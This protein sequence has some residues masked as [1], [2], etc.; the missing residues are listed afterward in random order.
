MREEV[1][2][3]SA[4]ERDRAS[5]V[6]RHVEEGLGQREA[7]EWL[8]I[9]VRQ[10]KRLVRDWRREGDAGL[11]S[12]QRGRPSNNRLASD[13]RAEITGL[14]QGKYEG[15]GPTLAAE[16]LAA[17]ENITVSAETLRQMQIGLGLWRPKKR[18][19]KRVFQ[20]RERRPRFGELIQI[21]GSPHAWFEGRGPRCTLI[22]FIDDATGRLTCLRFAPAE[23]TRAYLE[24][25]RDHVLA[26][27][28]QSASKVDPLSASNIDPLAS[29]FGGSG[30]PAKA[31]Q[32][33]AAGRLRWRDAQAEARFLKRQLSL[34]VSTISQW[35]VSRSSSAVV[36]L[37]SPNT[38]GHS[39]KARLV[40]TMT[41]VCS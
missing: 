18:R 13:R 36:I 41:E 25:L 32:G 19:V 7:S 26:H 10:F 17:V 30:R 5:L 3:M 11:T 24:A 16:K 34:P 12:R 4:P 35:W 15:F 40:V 39:P 2:G 37:A 38:F 23:S 31:G 28:C 1:L 9:G 8:R 14:L 20:L 21:D 27:G 22:V 33:C 29:I 6:R